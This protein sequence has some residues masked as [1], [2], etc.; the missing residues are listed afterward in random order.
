MFDDGS[1][2]LALVSNLSETDWTF[3]ASMVGGIWRIEDFDPFVM[4]LKS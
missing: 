4:I 2:C 3:F 1:D